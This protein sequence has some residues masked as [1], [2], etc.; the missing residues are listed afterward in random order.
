[1]LEFGCPCSH[2]AVPNRISVVLMNKVTGA[3]SHSSQCG[4]VKTGGSVNSGIHA[5]VS[6]SLLHANTVG[7][8]RHLYHT[9]H[10]V[11]DMVWHGMFTKQ[12]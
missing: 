1:M 7:H 3:C 8:D 2:D 12:A 4:T 11:W 10:S 9:G 5:Q 6:P